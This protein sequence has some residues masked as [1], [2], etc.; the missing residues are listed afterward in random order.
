M[1][2][3]QKLIASFHSGSTFYTDNAVNMVI[4]KDKLQELRTTR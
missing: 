1:T 3:A 2:A 4:I